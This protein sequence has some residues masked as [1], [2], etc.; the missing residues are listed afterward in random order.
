MGNLFVELC[1]FLRH[2]GLLVFMREYGDSHFHR[3]VS[4]V[5]QHRENG[6]CVAGALC[7]SFYKGWTYRYLFQ[8]ADIQYKYQGIEFVIIKV[9]EQE[10]YDAHI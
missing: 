5:T 4:T 9:I 3:S 10:R 1:L 6:N 2:E 8:S 7:Y